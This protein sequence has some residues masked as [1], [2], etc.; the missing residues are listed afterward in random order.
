[1]TQEDVI[2]GWTLF[3][4]F[5]IDAFK[6]DALVAFFIY[7]NQFE[8]GSAGIRTAN[9]KDSPF[10]FPGEI[11]TKTQ[12]CNIGSKA[13]PGVNTDSFW[14]S[15][16]SQDDFLSLIVYFPVTVIILDYDVD[17]HQIPFH[18]FDIFFNR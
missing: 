3:K 11:T 13:V 16:W 18:H 4:T 12:S 7:L 10:L 2:C 6:E 1:M 5:A 15:V 9:M 17:P 14:E 8:Q